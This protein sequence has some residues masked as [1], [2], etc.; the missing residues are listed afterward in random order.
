MLHFRLKKTPA[1]DYDLKLRLTFNNGEIKKYEY[2]W[3]FGLFPAWAQ[4][5]GTLWSV[6]INQGIVNCEI[7]FTE[8]P[9]SSV[10]SRP[11]GQGKNSKAAERAR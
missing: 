8:R 7:A 4:K 1:A 3:F 6:P 9:E 5:E 10:S 2:S 11:A